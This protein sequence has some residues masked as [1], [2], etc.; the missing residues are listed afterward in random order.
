VQTQTPSTYD[1]LVQ[2]ADEL[3]LAQQVVVLTRVVAEQER[4]IENLQLALQNSRTIGVALGILMATEKM[5]RADAFGVLSRASQRLN[6]K[7]SGIAEEV[8]HTGTLP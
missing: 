6:R 2:A 1:D 5:T 8:E 3:P 4:Q 7:L